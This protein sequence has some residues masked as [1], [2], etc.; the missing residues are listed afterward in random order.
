L[1]ELYGC[2]PIV[3]E[4][5]VPQESPSPAAI[6]WMARKLSAAGSDSLELIRAVAASAVMVG[7]LRALFSALPLLLFFPSMLVPQ[8]RWQ[9]TPLHLLTAAPV[10]VTSLLFAWLVRTVTE[11]KT[12]FARGLVKRIL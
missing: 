9:P 1:I 8:A 6:A 12:D 2:T 10:G 3:T 7:H 11:G 4:P 5:Q